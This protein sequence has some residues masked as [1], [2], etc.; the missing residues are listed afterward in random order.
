M[1]HSSAVGQTRG[2]AAT[3]PIKL[4]IE[5]RPS[6]CQSGLE[7]KAAQIYFDSSVHQPQA[8]DRARH[9]SVDC[10]EPAHTS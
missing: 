2:E 9:H 7:W 4:C 8:R 10:A 3:P 5:R 6:C 1:K